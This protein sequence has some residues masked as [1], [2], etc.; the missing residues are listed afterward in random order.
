MSYTNILMLNFK[1][2]LIGALKT[3]SFS[4][5]PRYLQKLASISIDGNQWYH[6]G[7][8]QEILYSACYLDWLFDKQ[9]YYARNY[10][11]ACL[12]KV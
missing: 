5:H 1:V 9:K 12:D 7:H 4:Y 2:L 11:E 8:N 3:Y 10:G 6:L